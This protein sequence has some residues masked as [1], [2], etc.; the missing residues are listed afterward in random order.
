[1]RAGACTR[2]YPPFATHAQAVNLAD[3]GI[4]GSLAK[5]TGDFRR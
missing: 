5:F 1:M 3:D 4:T 2:L